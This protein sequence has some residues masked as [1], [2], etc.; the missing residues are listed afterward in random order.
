MNYYIGVDGNKEYFIYDNENKKFN[1]YDFTLRELN[2]I[3][4]FHGSLWHFNPNY[5][6]PETLP[7]NLSLEENKKNDIYK[8]TLANKHGFEYYVVFDT[9]NYVAK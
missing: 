7:F 5:E 4:E 8:E 6:Y 1:L 2:I 3:I 9:D